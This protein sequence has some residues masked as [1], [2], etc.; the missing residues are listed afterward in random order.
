MCQVLCD[1]SCRFPGFELSGGFQGVPK[2][3]SE[4]AL[5]RGQCH[6][7]ED[8]VKTSSG[9]NMAVELSHSVKILTLHL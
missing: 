6:M 1:S 8:L 2:A 4:N 5:L 3:S 7:T 9:K